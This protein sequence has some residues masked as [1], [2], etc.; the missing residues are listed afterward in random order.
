MAVCLCEE[1]TQTN[2]K[3]YCNEFQATISPLQYALYS[4]L[5]LHAQLQL[6]FPFWSHILL[7]R[8]TVMLDIRLIDFPFAGDM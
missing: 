5:F 2:A 6:V 8:N 1:E 3:I 7:S 4:H